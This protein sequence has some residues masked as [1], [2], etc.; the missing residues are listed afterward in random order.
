MVSPNIAGHPGKQLQVQWIFLVAQSTAN[1]VPEKE[2]WFAESD[3]DAQIHHYPLIGSIAVGYYEDGACLY[4]V[5]EILLA[6]LVGPARRS[7]LD[8]FT[9]SAQTCRWAKSA[10]LRSKSC[11]R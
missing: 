3:R 7:R 2:C 10:A 5:G 4:D 9:R 11:S 6:K 8:Q 1:V